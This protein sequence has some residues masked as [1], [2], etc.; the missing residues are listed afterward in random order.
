RLAFR[1]A[2]DRWRL[3]AHPKTEVRKVRRIAGLHLLR[4]VGL[5]GEL[6]RNKNSH[7]GKKL[8]G[9]LLPNEGNWTK[10]GAKEP[11]S[12]IGRSAL[13]VDPRGFIVSKVIKAAYAARW[14]GR[15]DANF[16]HHH[17]VARLE[18]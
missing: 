7:H 14:K 9:G 6:K 3:A 5:R 15:N 16:R 11:C 1:A 12:A 4:I 17:R 8:L 18:P 13:D 2:H 10:N